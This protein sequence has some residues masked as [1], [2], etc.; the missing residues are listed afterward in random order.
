M[1]T[2]DGMDDHSVA[3]GTELRLDALITG[4]SSAA[5]AGITSLMV[6]GT[7]MT[8]A[9]VLAKAQA[10]VKPW[11]DGRA[12][13]AIVRAVAQ[14]RPQDETDARTFLSDVKIGLTAALGKTNQKLTD[15]GFKPASK[16]QALTT[17]QKVLRAAK[18]KLT[19]QKRHTMGSR[20]KADLKETG[21]PS[22]NIGPDGMAITAPDAA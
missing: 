7:S 6:G 12:A 13:H 2:P 5:S 20:Q 9:E 4:L 16:R 8:V 21:T 3:H 14:S 1:G 22:V 19:R 17:E 10:K 11:K 15:F 18:A